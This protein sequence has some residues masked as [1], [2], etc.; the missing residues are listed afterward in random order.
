MVTYD[1]IRYD[2]HIGLKKSEMDRLD[3]G[4]RYLTIKRPLSGPA[5]TYCKPGDLLW[6]SG[7][8]SHKSKYS[9]RVISNF[10]NNDKSIVVAARLMN[11][12]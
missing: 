5:S 4:D 2:G 12:L 3:K 7:E 8:N 1:E 9:L 10:T 11:S 6:A